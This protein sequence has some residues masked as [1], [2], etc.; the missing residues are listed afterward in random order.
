MVKSFCN[1]NNPK[2]SVTRGTAANTQSNQSMIIM[3]TQRSRMLSTTQGV[4]L[5]VD[6]ASG[7]NCRAASAKALEEFSSW[8]NCK[9]EQEQAKKKRRSEQVKIGHAGTLD[10][11]ATGCLPVLLGQATK[12]QDHLPIDV[13]R[14]TAHLRL[15]V[16]TDSDDAD[17]TVVQTDESFK[18]LAADFNL[19]PLLGQFRGKIMQTPPIYSAIHID[20]KRAYD[21]ARAGETPKMPAREVQIHRFEA[22][23]VDANTISLDISCGTGT[24]IR[25]LG[26]DLAK[27][28][29]TV[30]HLVKLRRVASGPFTVL[31]ERNPGDS[32]EIVRVLTLREAI[33][34]FT[35]VL[36]ISDLKHAQA[37]LMAGRSANLFK[38]LLPMISSP[39]NSGEEQMKKLALSW[40]GAI[41]AL[42]NV[43]FTK[44]TISSVCH[45]KHDE[46]MRF[47]PSLMDRQFSVDEEPRDELRVA[48]FNILADGLSYKRPDMGGFS[49]ISRACLNWEFRKL[50]IIEEIRRTRPHI[51]GLEEV[52]HWSEEGLQNEFKDIYQGVF[53]AKPNSP[54]LEYSN[55][56]DGC[57]MMFDKS[58]LKQIEEQ[59]ADESFS[60]GD[61]DNQVAA[62][63]VVEDIQFP[64]QRYVLCSTHLKAN[65][66]AHGASVRAR[67]AEYIASH[68][69][70]LRVKYSACAIFLCADLNT[71]PTEPAYAKL[72]SVMKSSMALLN[73]GN[74]P[75]FTTMKQRGDHATRH[76][77]DYIFFTNTTSSLRPVRYLLPLPSDMGF[78]P[79]WKY[80]SDHYLLCV[81]FSRS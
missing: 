19:D 30:G 9:P 81:G 59:V 29:G 20:G 11:M 31:E 79:S 77:I 54:C 44:G 60:L 57:V 35:E 18:G 38:D 75:E 50:R 45:F 41:G 62:C 7:I 48:Q 5:I 43:D 80:P 22:S 32:N 51:V 34:T 66:D 63:V 67:Q 28:I 21:L 4:V 16:K 47:V 58:R 70:E 23:T 8:T 40:S 1:A 33:E 61:Q 15:G 42:V 69:E 36:E 46:R 55:R 78:L 25:T 3:T 49:N 2:L 37:N 6:K 76:T 68:L 26:T 65:K 64:G 10:P 73:A 27:A 74:E 39:K 13:K 12:L 17:G 56:P 14:Y 72:S 53:K 71:V 24:Y 52:D